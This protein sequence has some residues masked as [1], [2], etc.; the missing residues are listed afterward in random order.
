[1]PSKKPQPSPNSFIFRPKLFE[2]SQYPGE[3]A[4]H[5]I[6]ATWLL[7]SIYIMKILKDYEDDEFVNLNS[8]LLAQVMGDA[9]VVA[10]VRDA[11]VEAEL[12]KCDRKDIRGF[13]SYGHKLTDSPIFAS[14]ERF[15]PDGERFRKRIVKFKSYI[16]DPSIMQRKPMQ[17]K[18][19]AKVPVIEHLK[20]NVRR[21]GFSPALEGVLEGLPDKQYCKEA[22]FG[23]K[24][25]LAR[26]QVDLFEGGFHRMNSCPYGRF[27]TNVT[28]MCRE[29]RP[30]L[31]IEGVPLWEIDISNSQPYF[32]ANM[33]VAEKLYHQKPQRDT[34]TT[35]H[36]K[37]L[38]SVPPDL[39][40]LLD[41]VATGTFYDDFV[42]DDDWTREEVKELLI[43]VIF[44]R[45]YQM[46][47]ELGGEWLEEVYPTLFSTIKEMKRKKGHAYVGREL[48]KL[49]SGVV[50]Y[51]VCDRLRRDYPH[52]PIITCHDSIATSERHLETVQRLFRE[53]FAHFPIQP[54]FKDPKPPY[55]V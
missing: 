21:A 44:G 55:V 9:G 8:R 42:L 13:K 15:Q 40:K 48:Q 20:E 38:S 14:W 37:G 34:P 33:A 30:C 10:K 45:V 26:N 7:S 29:L 2:A 6:E 4:N 3:I 22:Q 18:P 46:D 47:T 41:R 31:Q 17:S 52:I 11:M 32:L 24:K 50:I 23:T 1:M 36:P 27:H 25:E 51:N 5:P 35:T 49:E 54:H 53:G 12:I 19:I 28:G 39:V 16:A 43:R